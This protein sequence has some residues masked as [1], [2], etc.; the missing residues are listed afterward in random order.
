MS[1]TAN[2]CYCA[3]TL[4]RNLHIL[5]PKP[6]RHCCPS[7]EKK[8]TSLGIWCV[9]TWTLRAMTYMLKALKGGGGVSISTAK[10]VYM[11]IA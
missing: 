5:N 10:A 2:A 8:N 9:G 6:Y 1:T 7:L 3:R 11:G 4:D